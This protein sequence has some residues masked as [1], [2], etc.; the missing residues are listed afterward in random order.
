MEKEKEL[1]AVQCITMSPPAEH[2]PETRGKLLTSV[3]ELF[4]SLLPTDC[5]LYLVFQNVRQNDELRFRIR[6]QE[7]R[8]VTVNESERV[9][10]TLRE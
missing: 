8:D 2:L 5:I 10:E 9:E 4:L 7:G 1:D 6:T 3:V